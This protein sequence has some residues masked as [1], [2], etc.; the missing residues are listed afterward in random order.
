ML[1]ALE[2]QRVWEGLLE[3]EIR[4]H[5]FA[6]LC[7]RYQ[8]EQKYLTWAT[9]LFSSGAFATLIRD[10]VS[11]SFSW[12]PPILALATV[13]LSF[14]LLI[15]RNERNSI[16]CADLHFKQNMLAREF[17]DLWDD[18]YSDSAPEKLR[19]LEARAAEYSKTATSFPNKAK[20]MLQWENYVIQHRYRPAES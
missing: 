1:S 9:L 17:E 3:A 8:R 20:L 4:S 6:D 10:W 15:A 7:G 18:M 11:Q 5:Y 12:L 2:Q 16:E 13:G 19:Q 14:R